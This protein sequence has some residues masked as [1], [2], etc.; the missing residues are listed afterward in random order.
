MTKNPHRVKD[1]LLEGAAE[2]QRRNGLIPN[3]RL[4]ETI[5]SDVLRSL[6][7]K[8]A[9]KTPAKPDRNPARSAKVALERSGA[10]LLDAV[11]AR[12]EMRRMTPRRV[13]QT[14]EA[15]LAITRLQI[16]KFIPEWRR[17]IMTALNEGARQ[18]TQ[19]GGDMR[20]LIWM[21]IRKV[22]DASNKAVGY[23]WDRLPEK[24]A[25]VSG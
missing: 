2:A 22:L 3:T 23:R 14:P 8:D 25:T 24:K 7:Q 11:D 18:A 9:H 10:E 4:D 21:E 17:Q 1:K 12:R 15:K 16:L 13:K 19:L 5:W 20:L 6:D